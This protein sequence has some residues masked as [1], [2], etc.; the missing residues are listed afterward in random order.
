MT[1]H[2]SLTLMY[3]QSLQAVNPSIALPYWDFTIEGTL[4]SGPDF[5]DSKVFSDDW[6]GTPRPDNVRQS[7]QTNLNSS[8]VLSIVAKQFLGPFCFSWIPYVAKDSCC[9]G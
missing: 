6:F 3:E 2:I 5:R 9:G 4:Y 1:S 8:R 7:E